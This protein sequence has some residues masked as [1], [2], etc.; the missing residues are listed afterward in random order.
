VH[1]KIPLDVDLEDKLLYGLTPTRL[2]YLV[3]ALLTSFSIWSSPWSAAPIRVC[4]ASLIALVGVV[5]AWGRWHGRAADSWIVDAIRF[6]IT[7]YRL[8]LGHRRATLSP[9][10]PIRRPI[11]H[12]TIAESL[13]EAA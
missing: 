10:N 5:I 8:E 3:V 13:A 12:E 2:A 11:D 6:A 9:R 1:A 4:V 7:N